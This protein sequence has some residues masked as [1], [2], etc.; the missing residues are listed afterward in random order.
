MAESQL[1][2]LARLE[3]KQ[4]KPLSPSFCKGQY[5][6]ATHFIPVSS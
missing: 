6:E 1:S 3:G 5:P 2:E 4:R